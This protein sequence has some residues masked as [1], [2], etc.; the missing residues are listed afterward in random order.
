MTYK[1]FLLGAGKPSIGKVPS[2]L[3]NITNTTKAIDWQLRS[4]SEFVSIEDV[5][6]LGG[7]HIEKVIDY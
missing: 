5:H 2:A 3:K 1:L 4:F 7:Y 6:F